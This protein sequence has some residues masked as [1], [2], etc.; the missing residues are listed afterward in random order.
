MFRCLLFGYTVQLFCRV[1]ELFRL[2]GQ[3]WRVISHVAQMAS[4]GAG[5]CTEAVISV[6][7]L[8]QWKG[9]FGSMMQWFRLGTRLLQWADATAQRDNVQSDV[10]LARQ[11]PIARLYMWGAGS[12][13]SALDLYRFKRWWF[14][15]G[16]QFAH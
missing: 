13:G 9:V 2:L 12:N 3:L 14:L 16:A 8:A 5:V 1:V 10:R 11:L 15:D 7:V 6:E 4:G